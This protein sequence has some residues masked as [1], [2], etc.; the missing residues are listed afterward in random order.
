MTHQV[1]WL[2]LT[3]EKVVMNGS[4]R[5]AARRTTSAHNLK[6]VGLA[7]HNYLQHRE[8]FPPAATLDRLGRPV[9]GWQALIL[10]EM[11]HAEIHDRID[12]GLPWD[13]PRNAAPYQTP[14]MEYLRPGID[15]EK[16]T[17]GYALSHIAGNASVLGGTG[18][19]T[20]RDMTD[21][22]SN[23][24]MAGE[25]KS[26][27]KPWGDPT[28]WRDPA[29]GINRVANGFGSPAP[30][31]AHFLF[32]DGSVRFLK[33]KIDPGVLKALSTPSGGEKVVPDQY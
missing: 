18:L 24:I 20:S 7:L 32:V 28:N 15:L 33:E 4:A 21:G 25:V 31:G 23:T 11:A 2:M 6:Q 10:P 8:S 1:A 16:D 14:I 22:D 3:P 27:F 9:Y 26:N 13:D 29:L 17:S 19:R 30:G 12:F 5:E